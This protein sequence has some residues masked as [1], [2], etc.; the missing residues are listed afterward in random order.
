LRLQYEKIKGAKQALDDPTSQ[1]ST[2]FELRYAE[3]LAQMGERFKG[4][5]AIFTEPP[6]PIK[7][8]GTPQKILYLWSDSWIKR[9]LPIEIEFLKAGA[10]MFGVPKYAESLTKVAKNYGISTHL[11]HN[12]V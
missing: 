5:K 1:V 2:I 12:L 10:T 8:G 4:G 3:K 6:H 7:C 11:Q 9:S